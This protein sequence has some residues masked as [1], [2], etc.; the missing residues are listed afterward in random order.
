MSKK[1]RSSGSDFMIQEGPIENRSLELLAPGGSLA[2]VKAAFQ[3][4]ADAVYMGGDRF[5]A[6]AYAES[7]SEHSLEEAMDYAHL[8]G[9]KLYLTLNTLLKQEEMEKELYDFVAP[10]YTRGVDAVLVQDLG[11]AAFLRR[12]FPDLPLHASTQMT[13]TSAASARMLKHLGMTRVVA[14]REL[15]LKELHEIYQET[16]ME[17]EAFVH[18]AICYCYS[19]QCLY[20]GVIGGRSGNRG[21]CAQPCRLPYTAKD[22]S[23]RALNPPSESWLL[24]LKDMC[25]LQY[26]PDMAEAGVMSFKIEGRM[27]SPLYTAGVV[28]IYRKYLDQ[29]LENGRRNWKIDSQDLY[30]LSQY[31][32][33]G[34]F[35][36]Q[37][38]HSHN[39]RE[40]MALKEKTRMRTPDPALMKETES[41]YLNQELRESVRGFV[42]IQTGEPAFIRLETNT[43]SASAISDQPVMAAEKR[44]LSGADVEKQMRKT[45]GTPFVMEQLEVELSENAFLPVQQMNILRREA[46]QILEQKILDSAR[47]TV[48]ETENRT[49]RDQ[50][51]V[52]D[53]KPVPNEKPVPCIAEIFRMEQLNPVLLSGQIDTVYVDSSCVDRNMLSDVAEQ[54]HRA[55]KQCFLVLPRIWREAAEKE[56]KL[57]GEKILQSG[58]DGVT[59][60]SLDAL[61]SLADGKCSLPV[62]IDHTLYSWNQEAKAEIRKLAEDAG[63]RILRLTA[64]LELNERELKARGLTD[65]ELQIYGRTPMMVTAGCIRKTTGGCNHKNDLVTLIDRKKMIFPVQCSCKYCYNV[66]YNSLPCYLLDR[67][68][69]IETLHPAAFRLAFT[70]EDERETKLVLQ[71]LEQFRR[72]AGLN[73]PALLKN[74]DD[75]SSAEKRSVKEITRGHFA[76]G[77]Q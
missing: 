71:D 14:A 68:E 51:V 53:E 5:S 65:S 4:G 18:G 6:R 10:L 42:S 63:L 41:R 13:V 50:K 48:K 29:Y 66:I 67:M 74:S 36:D 57:N 30:A 46:L 70:V 22:G 37:Y 31:F 1:R 12:E 39:G 25:T 45:G 23:G 62:V 26:L 2:G 32:D 64:P 9:R 43:V 47:R 52:P 58:I 54:C 75:R 55:G 3:A 11:A 77:V 40:M 61:Q 72:T 8:H 16:G 44:P 34:G 60:G 17:L 59:A 21:R 35:T 15:N 69:Q 49:E 76:R 56:W 7:A 19:G 73:G 20:S 28:S 24:S 27:K 38:L 33:R